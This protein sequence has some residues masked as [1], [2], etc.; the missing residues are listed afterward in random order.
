MSVAITVIL[1]TR[2]IKEN[3]K[4]PVKLRVNFKRVTNNYQTIFNLSEEEYRMLSAPGISAD[5]QSI[6]TN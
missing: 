4:Y 1:D 5:L 2:R 3:N 6:K